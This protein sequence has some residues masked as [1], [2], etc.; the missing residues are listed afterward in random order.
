MYIKSFKTKQT[1]LRTFLKYVIICKDDKTIQKYA[2]Q[3]C[4]K[5]FNCMQID[6]RS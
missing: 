6:A 5:V 2:K 4:S 1:Y 3:I